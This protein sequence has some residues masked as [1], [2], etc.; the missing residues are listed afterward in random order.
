MPREY[1]NTHP[2]WGGAGFFVMGKLSSPAQYHKLLHWRHDMNIGD[3]V[4]LKG[5]KETAVIDVLLDGVYT[6]G[7][8][9]DNALD[10]FRYWHMDDLESVEEDET[11]HRY[12]L[13]NG[14][15]YEIK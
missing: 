14:K 10:G 6:G 4:K 13:I 12:A 1:S 3:R 9:L 11:I 5:K 2:Q 7:V 8:R 15:R